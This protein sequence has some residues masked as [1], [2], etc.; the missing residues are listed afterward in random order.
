MYNYFE[1]RFE[2]LQYI[3]NSFCNNF[4]LVYICVLDKFC[5]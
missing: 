2:K 3:K 5:N 4:S 1:W